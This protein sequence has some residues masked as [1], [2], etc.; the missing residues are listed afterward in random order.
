[1]A[2]YDLEVDVPRFVPL[3]IELSVCAS[4]DHFRSHVEVAVLARLTSGVR[5]D[6]TLGT[7]HPDR[8]TFAQPVYLS[9]IIA[10]VQNVPGVQS[11]TAIK[12]QRLRDDS[13]DAVDTGVLEMSRLEIA[14]L[15]A[16]PNY[17]ERG[18][19]TIDVGGGK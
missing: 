8:F 17:P 6:G 14:R 3:E 2:G 4:P 19:L 7:F 5:A 13:T 12:F 9:A 15:D 11:V 1:M 18:L 16:D 10:E